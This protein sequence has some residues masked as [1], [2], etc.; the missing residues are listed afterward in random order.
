[1]SSANLSQFV[2]YSESSAEPRMRIRRPGDLRSQ[3][4]ASRA[5]STDGGRR[6]AEI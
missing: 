2:D 4:E 3:G 1:M 6:P 5:R